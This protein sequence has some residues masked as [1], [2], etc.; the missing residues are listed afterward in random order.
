MAADAQAPKI[1]AEIP[2]LAASLVEQV[3]GPALGPW[4]MD[5]A[6]GTALVLSTAGTGTEPA[7]AWDAF[8][9]LA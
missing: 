2:A 7:S 5:G 1:A 9:A 8:L 6:A 4:L 3:S